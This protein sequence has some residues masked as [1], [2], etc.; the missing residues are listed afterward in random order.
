VLVV[1]VLSFR[2]QAAANAL[3]QDS[4]NPDVAGKCCAQAINNI[5][6]AADKEY[7]PITLIILGLE[8][9]Y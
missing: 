4:I 8:M 1:D 7:T 2:G 6:L 5:R 3:L 9:P